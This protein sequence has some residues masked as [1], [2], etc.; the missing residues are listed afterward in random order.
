MQHEKLREEVLFTVMTKIQ[1]QESETKVHMHFFCITNL[2]K[3]LFLSQKLLVT[4]VDAEMAFTNVRHEDFVGAR[5]RPKMNEEDI[6]KSTTE[7]RRAL[8]NN[9]KVNLT[10]LLKIKFDFTT[11][12]ENFIIKHFCRLC[13]RAGLNARWAN[14]VKN[15]FGLC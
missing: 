8:E 13:K 4:H 2:Y 10:L 7:V 1:D 12:V 5:T 3:I 15:P 6:H 11:L 14:S 9:S